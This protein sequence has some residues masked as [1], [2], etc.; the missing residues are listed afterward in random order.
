MTL[1]AQAEQQKNKDTYVFILDH[2][3][4]K[5]H[6][7]EKINLALLEGSVAAYEP[8]VK[9]RNYYPVCFEHG[10]LLTVDQ[11]V[12]PTL[13]QS[14]PDAHFIF[15]YSQNQG[16][17]YQ[18][19]QFNTIGRDPCSAC[20]PSTGYSIIQKRYAVIGPLEN[21]D[22]LLVGIWHEDTHLTTCMYHYH[23]W[24]PVSSWYEP[25]QFKSLSWCK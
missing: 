10:D 1:P 16:L 7:D 5:N 6:L 21:L 25:M 24:D 18:A 8:Y 22:G 12:V 4:Y 15:V 11:I 20:A 17:Q 19:W 2:D 3:C 23:T 9:D 14:I 13:R